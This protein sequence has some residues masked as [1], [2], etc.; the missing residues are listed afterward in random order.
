MLR[1][2]LYKNCILNET[3]QN[4][5]STGL[6]NGKS[7]LERYLETLSQFT[8]TDIDDAYYTDNNVLNIDLEL[9][10][11]ANIYEYNYMK[12][13]YFDEEEHLKLTRYCF[14]NN[15]KVKNEIVQLFYKED[16]FST[17]SSG[18]IG[19]QESYLVKSRV[20]SYSNKTI[21][22]Y[23]LPVNYDGNKPPKITELLNLPQ[24]AQYYLLAEIQMY[25]LGQGG[26]QTDRTVKYLNLNDNNNTVG[27]YRTNADTFIID[28]VENMSGGYIKKVST[29]PP[30]NTEYLRYEIGDIYLFPCALLNSNISISGTYHYSFVKDELGTGEFGY[31]NEI[32]GVPQLSLKR[33][34]SLPV[35]F[36]NKYLGTLNKLIEIE[37]TG[38][39]NQ[40][41][42]YFSKNDYNITIYLGFQNQLVDITESYKLD[43]PVK[44]L[45]SEEL[46]QIRIARELKNSNLDYARRVSVTDLTTGI[47]SSI[48]SMIGTVF[49]GKS[50][51]S[52][53]T[54]L[55]S[56]GTEMVGDILKGAFKLQNIAD[57]RKAINAKMYA[58]NTGIFGNSANMVNSTYGLILLEIDSVNNEYV[59]K[60]INNFG[61]E[62]F[63]FVSNLNEIDFSNVDYYT[64]NNINYNSIK[65]ETV[66][67][68]GSFTNEIA[69]KLNEILL[70][71]VKIW[72]N[73]SLSED[74]LIQ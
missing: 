30:Y 72:Y 5:I 65:F 29:E 52:K 70:S 48:S 62:T 43:V 31:C 33:T 66:N 60:S 39:V 42:V 74:N 25:K 9:V 63:E 1:I 57:N 67:V 14:V 21:S 17:Y 7:V 56:E 27:I 15:I 20:I 40:I 26:A 32:L 16:I 61:Y 46:S 12:I 3:Y 45:L 36:K 34:I 55:V 19:I 64:N 8:I 58:S 35:N 44:S 4:V 53:I 51:G 69:F 10:N 54:S 59:K 24:L 71:G 13:L 11:N 50:K 2:T 38:L 37:H 28:I 23:K 47:I 18:I 73:E 41:N 49:S 68:Y 6:K 22:P